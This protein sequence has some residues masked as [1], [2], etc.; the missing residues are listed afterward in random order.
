[1]KPWR[2]YRGAEL[3]I[4]RL[5]DPEDLIPIL[6]YYPPGAND[7][8]DPN[9]D[10]EAP[11]D[12]SA[13][14]PWWEG[15]VLPEKLPFFPWDRVKPP[16]IDL[17]D[18]GDCDPGFQLPPEFLG[19]PPELLIPPVQ[20]PF[21]LINISEHDLPAGDHTIIARIYNEMNDYNEYTLPLHIEVP[22]E[23][24][25]IGPID[26]VKDVIVPV[27]SHTEGE[28]TVDHNVGNIVQG[29]LTLVNNSGQ[30]FSATVHIPQD[31]GSLDIPL[32][33][34]TT[35]PNK[36]SAPMP[37]MTGPLF[38]STLEFSLGGEPPSTIEFPLHEVSEEVISDIVLE[39]LDGNV[40]DAIGVA[41]MYRIRASVQSRTP[42]N[43]VALRV[44]YNTIS[45]RSVEQD[46]RDWS[47]PYY[48]GHAN[49]DFTVSGSEVLQWNPAGVI[50][51]W[52]MMQVVNAFGRRQESYE[53]TPVPPP[54]TSERSIAESVKYYVDEYLAR[55]L[56]Y[57][58]DSNKPVKKRPLRD[59]KAK[60][61]EIDRKWPGGVPDSARIPGT[62]DFA[63]IDCSALV[64][65]V[66]D[67]VRLEHDLPSLDEVLGSHYTNSGETLKNND[68]FPE[69][70]E[71]YKPKAGA[72]ATPDAGNVRIKDLKAGDFMYGKF[73]EYG[74]YLLVK[75]VE[76]NEDGTYD[77]VISHS[78]SYIK[79]GT[80]D[81]N[82]PHEYR[83]DNVS[84]ETGTHEVQEGDIEVEENRPDAEYE[85]DI[86]HGMT[87]V[88]RDKD[89]AEEYEKEEAGSG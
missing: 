12:G 48:L 76:E 47:F 43:Q 19:G 77:A 20:V 7:P 46:I 83:I 45:G 59:G 28:S 8:E 64:Y 16:A 40:P 37:E 42:F 21:P 54:E 82:G 51:S 14:P 86:L 44:G 31:G 65:N 24:P 49:F 30:T 71:Y 87:K 9:Y 38:N 15:P 3:M 33:Q 25:G 2:N 56:I 22:V 4:A 1:M 58:I 10:P 89:L 85:K 55:D 79:E 78:S 57:G 66:I 26:R 68:Q 36:Y 32:T 81:K 70:K 61:E 73:G 84:G 88:R 27:A 67:Y 39:D 72:A 5:G 69:L 41:N 52:L 11:P 29:L 62:E 23:V 63:G 60:L 6:P 35:D 34:D 13:N 17:F 75:E 80:D 50:E 18:P 53:K 74:H